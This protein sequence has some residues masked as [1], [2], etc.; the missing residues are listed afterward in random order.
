MKA[1]RLLAAGALALVVTACAQFT[2]PATNNTEAVAESAYIAAAT[3]ESAYN[4][5]S[6]CAPGVSFAITAPCKETAVIRQVKIA[7]NN[8]YAALQTMRDFRD[9]HPEN[10]VGI[11]P[12]VDAALAA[13]NALKATIPLKS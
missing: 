7:D 5:L 3:L 11:V 1:F 4:A 12:L 13:V 10:K 2:N 6:F 9:A 8:A